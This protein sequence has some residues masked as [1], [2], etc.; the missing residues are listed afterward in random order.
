MANDPV[1]IENSGRIPNSGGGGSGT[2]ELVK[3]SSNDT[4]ASYLET[5]VTAGTGV[6]LTVL[7]DGLNE[8]LQIAS[9]ATATAN[10]EDIVVPFT[11]LS[12]A[13]ISITTLTENATISKVR[14]FIETVF[15]DAT[16][17]L[18]V[19][20]AGNEEILQATN[21]N[22]L[23]SIGSYESWAERDLVVGNE[24]QIFLSAG[25]STQGSGRVVVTISR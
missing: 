12:G 5:K 3:V 4:T 15:N 18:S 20:L 7:N 25:T 21:E 10:D 1:E 6:T 19:G 16:A 24:L 11:Y 22:D 13:S 14:T 9:T 17:T 23:T 2:D 8:S